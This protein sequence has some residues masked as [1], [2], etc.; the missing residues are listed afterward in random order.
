MRRRAFTLIELLVVIAIIALLIGILLPAL[1]K[2]REAARLMVSQQ[3]M[4]QLAVANANHASQNDEQMGGYNWEAKQLGGTGFN[5]REFDIG[6]G[7]T[8]T[9]YNNLG[10]AQAQQVAV[11]RKATGRCGTGPD[12]IKFD[13]SRLVHR[14]Y[15]HVPMVD[16]LTGQQPEPIAVSPLD[17]HHLDFQ[18]NPT[19]YTNLPGGLGNGVSG[20]SARQVVN[21]WPFASSYQSTVY[22]WSPERPDSSGE[23]ALEP[24][25]DSTLIYVRRPNDIIARGMF[26][27]SLPSMKAFFFEEFDY[28]KGMG[29]QA[30]Y[31][32]DPK[33]QINVQ[34]FDS[35]VRRITTG[36]PT[37]DSSRDA[38]VGHEANPGW[39]AA[40]PCDN[41]E[42]PRMFYEPID[43]RFFPDY[44]DET[45]PGELTA[46]PGYYKWTR[47]GL[48]GLDVGGGEISTETWCR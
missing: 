36:T 20:W 46:F 1:G 23:M 15:L 18:E 45:A 25:E 48:K 33:A 32:A 16:E 14:R 3:N 24:A 43:A 19:D 21:R 28:T 39:D 4:K 7:E 47:G 13:G 34:F 29:N 10:A 40:S 8:V 22:A 12:A 44:T 17:V 11:I 31:Y 30:A 27:V 2:A 42:L 37:F 26:E 5:F 9:P 38:W 41:S 35:S 6:C